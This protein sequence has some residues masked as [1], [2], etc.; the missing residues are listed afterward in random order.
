[1]LTKQTN[2]L[3]REHPEYIVISYNTSGTNNLHVLT[4]NVQAFDGFK[5]YS[6]Y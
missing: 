5:F 2:T 4:Y 1:M 3:V 6:I